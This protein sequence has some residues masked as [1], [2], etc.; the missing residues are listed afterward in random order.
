[1]RQEQQ[2]RGGGEE[3]EGAAGG[4][5]AAAAAGADDDDSKNLDG[6]EQSPSEPPTEGLDAI[7]ELSSA[8]AA[9]GED[10]RLAR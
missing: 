10:E 9:L 4:A 6:G 3:E 2:Q 8:L 5:S 7:D 1:M